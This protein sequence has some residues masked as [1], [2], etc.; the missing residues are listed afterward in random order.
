MTDLIKKTIPC[1]L[2]L[3]LFLACQPD[4]TQEKKENTSPK[5]TAELPK[6]EVAKPAPA[7][8]T[9]EAKPAEPSKEVDDE[10]AEVKEEAS[11][12]TVSTTSSE[13]PKKKPKAKKRPKIS[14]ASSTHDYGVIMQG[15]KVEHK[16]KFTN[17]GAADLLITN[18]SVSCGCTHPSYPFIPIKPGEEGS[19][20]VVFDSKG[21]LGRQTPTITVVTNSRPTTYKL[22]LQGFVDAER[23]PEKVESPEVPEATPE[24]SPE[25][26]EGK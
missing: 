13:K 26:G 3:F 7:E 23:A 1:L 11:A 18:V 2:G 19:I 22:K 16:F 15:D 17:K 4:T 6:E 8:E 9:S 5:T 21:K 24:K 20:G 10:K 25:E 12:K 14:F